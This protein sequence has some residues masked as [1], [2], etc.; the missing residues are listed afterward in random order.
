MTEEVTTSTAP[1]ACMNPEQALVDRRVLLIDAGY[2]WAWAG[3]AA[4]FAYSS[5]TSA[6]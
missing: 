1:T 5:S 2:A 4:L 6:A 3:T